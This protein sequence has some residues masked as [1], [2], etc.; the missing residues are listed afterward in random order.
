MV[1]VPDEAPDPE[2]AMEEVASPD[3]CA[4][5]WDDVSAQP[6]LSVRHATMTI[7]PMNLVVITRSSLVV[8]MNWL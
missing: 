6:A 2:L 5:S 7:G 3:D 4:I 1:L 8:F